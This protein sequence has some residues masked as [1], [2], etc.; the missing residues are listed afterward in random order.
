MG[1]PRR[2]GPLYGV[3]A[4]GNA[5]KQLAKAIRE[6]AKANQVKLIELRK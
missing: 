2:H 6:W 1:L 5:A 4:W 3:M